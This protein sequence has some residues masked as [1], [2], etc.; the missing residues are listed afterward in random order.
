MHHQKTFQITY[1]M[2]MEVLNI[3]E[4]IRRTRRRVEYGIQKNDLSSENTVILIVI[5][6]NLESQADPH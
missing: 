5:V 4:E 2:N 1:A 3:R 6:I